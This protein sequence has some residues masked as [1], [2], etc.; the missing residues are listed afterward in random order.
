MLEFE[1]EKEINAPI[2]IDDD[3]TMLNV[4]SLQVNASA[5][6]LKNE[7]K[8]SNESTENRPNFTE[9][10]VNSHSAEPPSNT[11]NGCATSGGQ[12]GAPGGLIGEELTMP[13]N[14]EEE[15]NRLIDQILDLQKTQMI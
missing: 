8:A 13:V 7:K 14:E 11:E 5:E 6:D 3:N 4:L 10:P 2:D 15:T 12:S 9:F 1:E